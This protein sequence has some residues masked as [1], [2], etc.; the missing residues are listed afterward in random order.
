MTVTLK[1]GSS[2]V[3]D[4]GGVILSQ[5]WKARQ[6]QAIIRDI[7]D[8]QLATL[9]QQQAVDG[10]VV[11]STNLEEIFVAYMQGDNGTSQSASAWNESREAIAGS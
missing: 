8:D 5:R 7:A 3:P 4:F 1:N 10:V 2:T 9:A 11:H 6:W